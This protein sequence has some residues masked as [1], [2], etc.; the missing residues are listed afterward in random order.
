MASSAEWLERLLPLENE[1]AAFWLAAAIE[2]MN[3]PFWGT[4]YEEAV[5][6]MAAHRYTVAQRALEGGGAG[7]VTSES[8]NGVARSYAAPAA[9]AGEMGQTIYGQHLQTLRRSRSL[10]VR[11][12]SRPAHGWGRG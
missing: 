5:A 9:E 6:Y 10:N 12:L 7:A 1:V 4:R 3:V 8:A 11:G 2:S